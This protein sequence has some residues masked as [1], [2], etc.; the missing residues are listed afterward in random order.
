[1]ISSFQSRATIMVEAAP[2]S[3]AELMRHVTAVGIAGL[4]TGF[5]VGGIGGRLFMRVAGAAAPESAQGALTE[6][7]FT[8]GEITAGETIGLIVFIGGLVGVVGGVLYAVFRPWLA[9]TG[10]YRGVAFGVVLFAV[11]SATS[12]VMNPDNIDFAVLGNGPLLVSMIA[13]LFLLFGVVI[14]R[15]YRSV[16]P[17]LPAASP[18]LNRPKALYAVAAVFGLLIAVGVVPGLLFS[19]GQ[20]DCEPPL[21][22]S[23]SVVVA[24]TGT[25]LWWAAG[26]SPRLA[27]AA[28]A[29]RIL[30]FVGLAG[31]TIF[32]LIRAIGDAAEILA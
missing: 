21:L 8:V 11:A 18:G 17:R 26:I 3:A 27:R 13:L 29:A 10:A 30:G 22:A 28:G 12:D 5:V 19:T 4:V 14:D 31:A 20:C 25:L 9:W 6:A 1:V 7:G 16:G 32:G 15:L 23:A 24:A 2:P